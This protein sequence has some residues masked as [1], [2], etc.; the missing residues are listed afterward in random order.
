MILHVFNADDH[1]LLEENRWIKSRQANIH[2]ENPRIGRHPC[3]GV[4]S[5]WSSLLNKLTILMQP[6]G[7]KSSCLRTSGMKQPS[8]ST[9]A[10]TASC[11]EVTT[12]ESLS[13]SLP[14]CCWTACYATWSRSSFLRVRVVPAQIEEKCMDQLDDLYTTFMTK[15]WPRPSTQSAEKGS[16]GSCPGSAALKSSLQ[17]PTRTWLRVFV[18]IATKQT[19]SQ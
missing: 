18:M 2:Q 4:Q 5:S 16:G 15:A 14:V 1:E 6:T 3:W 12:A 19:S 10:G 9:N 8:T 13:C 7:K 11:S 17:L